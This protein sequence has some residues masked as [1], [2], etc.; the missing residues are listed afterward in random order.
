[1]EDDEDGQDSKA[2]NKLSSSDLMKL[3]EGGEDVVEDL[4]L[5]DDDWAAPARLY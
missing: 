5:S 4:E 1:M 3:A 2:P